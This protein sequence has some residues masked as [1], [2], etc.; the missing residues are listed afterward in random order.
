MPPLPMMEPAAAER[1]V[2]DRGVEERFGEASAGRTA[3]LHRLEALAVRD[4]AADVEDHLAQ[5]R[6][7]GHF[8]QA[9]VAHLAGQGEDLGALALLGAD[10][11]EPVGPVQD[12]H[13]DVGQRLD[14]VDHGGLAPQ[15]LS[16]G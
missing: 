9:R 15:A 7:H 10:G 13:G 5:R 16:A 8:D 6:A 11:G 3:G 12:D 4:A 2:V 14:V 1:V